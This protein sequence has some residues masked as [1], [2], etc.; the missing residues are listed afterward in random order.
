[1]FHVLVLAHIRVDM[2]NGALKVT[3]GGVDPVRCFLNV[4]GEVLLPYSVDS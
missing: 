4:A 3:V 2:L 1:M